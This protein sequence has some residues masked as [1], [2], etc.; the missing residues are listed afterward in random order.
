MGLDLD[1]Y[2]LCLTDAQASCRMTWENQDDLQMV[3]TV[4]RQLVLI[5][6]NL[7]YIFVPHPERLILIDWSFIEKWRYPLMFNT[8]AW[9]TIILQCVTIKLTKTGTGKE[10]VMTN[11]HAAVDY[12]PQSSTPPCH[13]WNITQQSLTAPPFILIKCL[14]LRCCVATCL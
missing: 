4:T 9:K 6:I 3:A 10:D 1:P 5:V 14:P 12:H 13:I 7:W 8:W 11:L 2:Y